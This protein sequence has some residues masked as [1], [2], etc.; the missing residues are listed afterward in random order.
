MPFKPCPEC[1]KEVRVIDNNCW[2]C[3][4]IFD[5]ALAESQAREKEAAERER[6]EAYSLTR[7]KASND[8]WWGHVV[9]KGFGWSL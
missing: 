9:E 5:P 6:A 3:D 2:N 7:Q 8:D 1:S 4:H